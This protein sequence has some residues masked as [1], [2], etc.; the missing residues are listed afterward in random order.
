MRAVVPR[1]NIGIEPVV[2]KPGQLHPLLFVLP[3]PVNKCLAQ[4]IC[5]LVGCGGLSFVN[6]HDGLAAII[7]A[8]F[9]FDLN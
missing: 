8:D 2:V 3:D 9:G 6:L 5:F 7:S 4:F 1:W